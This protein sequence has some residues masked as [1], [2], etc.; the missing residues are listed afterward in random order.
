M[1]ID[2][3]IEEDQARSCP[4]KKPRQDIRQPFEIGGVFLAVRQADI[5]IGNRLACR[6]ISL[7][8]HGKGEDAGVVVENLGGSVALVD[9]EID[10]EDSLHVARG[11]QLQRRDPDIVERAETRP[12]AASDWKPPSSPWSKAAY[13]GP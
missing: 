4:G 10:D 2:A 12:S 5:E 9:V 3:C 6:V 13:S 1:R 7:A 8:M 11:K